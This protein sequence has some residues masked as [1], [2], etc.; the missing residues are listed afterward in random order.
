MR[1]GGVFSPGHGNSQDSFG[2][3]GAGGSSGGG[4]GSGGDGGAG[5]SGGG[6]GGGSVQEDVSAQLVLVL[7]RLQTDMENVLHRLNTLETLTVTQH[8]SVCHHCQVS[9]DIICNF[10][11]AVTWFVRLSP[12]LVNK[13]VECDY[14]AKREIRFTS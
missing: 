6:G 4:G 11:F 3:G 12:L 1:S 14:F 5:G 7:R 9:F 2:R 13:L 8:H 10:L